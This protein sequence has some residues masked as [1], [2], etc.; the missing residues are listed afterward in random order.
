MPGKVKPIPEGYHAVTPYLSVIG[1]AKAIAFYGRAFGAKELLRMPMP[2]GRIGHAELQ[3]GD[4]RIMLADE[5]QMA[6][7]V[8]KSPASAGGTSVGFLLYVEDVDS[9]FKQAVDAG[10]TVKRPIQNQFY[11]DRSGTIED[12]FGHVWTLSSHVE[13]VSP[14]EMNRRMAALTQGG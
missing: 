6:D 1:A 10:A 14:E 3:I 7:A 9:A 12:P 5:N 11:G 2:D 8:T 13:D 4:A